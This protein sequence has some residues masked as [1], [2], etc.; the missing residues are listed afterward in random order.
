MIGITHLPIVLR[1]LEVLHVCDVA[2][3]LRRVSLGGPQLGSFQS[4]A[5][6]QPAFASPGPDDHVKLFFADSG[7]GILTLPVQEAHRLRWP[8][9]PRAL[10]REYTPRAFN[11]DSGRLDLDFVRHDEGIAADWAYN[12]RPGD[13]IHV[14]GP[15]ASMAMP[16]ARRAILFGDETAI[17]AIANW[18]E[19]RPPEMAVVAYV[20]SD[21]KA[22]HAL[23]PS[24]AGV[25]VIWQQPIVEAD[26]FGI[27]LRSI[28][29]AE[30]DFVWCG[31]EKASADALRRAL[32]RIGFP[33]SSSDI[34][35]Y[36]I[37]NPAIKR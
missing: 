2:P 10:S 1:Q 7:S 16:R 23:L 8:Q 25:E 31:C 27:I 14:A 32:G 3:R 35:N 29:M 30:E 11:P 13:R 26:E 15:K 22:M 6:P 24:S 12:T 34:C 20:F 19:M 36:W 21:D 17:P 28:D 9:S 4:V 37:K 18:C 33:S 5:G